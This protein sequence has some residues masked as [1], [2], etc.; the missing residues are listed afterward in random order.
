M[1][2]NLIAINDDYFLEEQFSINELKES[3]NKKQNESDVIISKFRNIIDQDF[4]ADEDVKPKYVVDISDEDHELMQQNVIK[5]D[6]KDGKTYAQFRNKN[7]KFGKKLT[8]KEEDLE[9][10]GLT[11]LQLETAL[12]NKAIELQLENILNTLN[13][14]EISLHEIRQGQQNDRIGMF[15]SAQNQYLESLSIKDESFR[16]QMVS[17]A[18]KTLSD[19]NAQMIQD[20]KTDVQFL[21]NKEYKKNK[22]N[23]KEIV[24]EKMN[25]I[26][27]NFEMI[28]KS[29]IS[30]AK[31]YY[32]EGELESSLAVIR[33]YGLFIE[34]LIVPYAARISE[35][36]T[37][38]NLL[39]GGVWE[40]RAALL[41][42]TGKAYKAIAM[43]KIYYI[44]SRVN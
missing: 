37:N 34:K 13:D 36:D 16:K 6:M 1:N 42:D 22:T 3:I 2:T 32:D 10:N 8:I 4:N 33:E 15:F 9:A 12:Q 39:S 19:A 24:N 27:K 38:D 26:H 21:I 31:I 7:G 40:K 35:F 14:I 20:F 18:I 44:E 17:Q 5:L 11:Q 30:K 28:N 25:N 23:K 43:N 29:Y 41:T